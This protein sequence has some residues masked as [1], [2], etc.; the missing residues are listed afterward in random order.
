MIILIVH[1]DAGVRQELRQALGRAGFGPCLVAGGLSEARSWQETAGASVELVITTAGHA[2]MVGEWRAA[3]GPVRALFLAEGDLS[4]WAGRLPGELLLPAVP[5]PTEA[6]V[7][8]VTALSAERKVPSDVPLA[9]PAAA[10]ALPPRFAPP[11]ESA[12]FGAPAVAAAG[13]M[14]RPRRAAPG[15][16]EEEARGAHTRAANWRHPPPPGSAPAP[17]PLWARLEAP[18]GRNE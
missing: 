15:A 16:G 13:P 1:D 8:W 6:V 7:G 5:L 3:V 2:S 17:A 14:T 12:G 4:A 18:G 11:P 9:A 10:V